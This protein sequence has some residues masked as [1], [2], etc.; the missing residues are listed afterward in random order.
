MNPFSPRWWS[1][2]A[3]V[4]AG[5][6]VTQGAPRTSANYFQ[7][8]ESLNAAGRLQGSANYAAFTS[9]GLPGG[10]QSSASYHAK[11]GPVVPLAGDSPATGPLPVLLGNGHFIISGDTTPAAEDGTDYGRVPVQDDPL[12]HVFTLRNGGTEP[13]TVSDITKSGAGAGEFAVSGVTFPLTLTPGAS[14]EL[15][16]AFDPVLGARR[17]ANLRINFSTAGIAP[18][19]FALQGFGLGLIQVTHLGDSGP[20]SLRDAILAANAQEGDDVIRFAAGVLGTLDLRTALPEVT[21][22]LS[23]EGPGADRLVINRPNQLGLDNIPDFRLFP[24]A[25]GF[26]GRFGLKGVTLR[27]GSDPLAGVVALAAGELVA[28]DCV[29]AGNEATGGTDVTLATGAAVFRVATGAALTAVRCRFEQNRNL[30]LP[31]A[32]LH[33]RVCVVLGDSAGAVELTDCAFRENHT[34]PLA[35]VTL[36]DSPAVLRRCRFEDNYGGNG[37]GLLCLPGANSAASVLVLDGLFL[38]NRS[39]QGGAILSLADGLRVVNSTFTENHSDDFGGAIVLGGSLVGNPA[40]PTTVGF[41]G[42]TAEFVNCT[43][44]GNQGPRT[45]FEPAQGAGGIAIRGLRFGEQIWR[46]HARLR[47]TVVADNDLE[48]IGQPGAPARLDVAWG[49]LLGDLESQGWNFIGA[50]NTNSPAGWI[51]TDRFGIPNNPLTPGLGPLGDYGGPLPTLLPLRFSPLVD[52]ANVAGLNLAADARGLARTLDRPDRPNAAGSDGTDI[53][54]A[55][56]QPPPPGVVPR[57]VL[58]PADVTVDG[59]APADLTA[60]AFGSEPLTFTWRKDGQPVPGGVGPVLHFDRTLPSLAGGYELV[61]A[62]AFGSVTSQVAT[63][64]VRGNFVVNLADHGPGSLR[65]QIIAANANPGPDT[66]RLLVDSPGRILL[67]TP[68]PNIFGELT[69]IGPGPELLALEARG[70]QGLRT[71]SA[72]RLSLMGLAFR[73]FDSGN[74]PVLRIAGSLVVS[75]CVFEANRGAVHGLMDSSGAAEVVLADSRFVDNVAGADLVRILG[76][77]TNR[78]TRCVFERN[79]AGGTTLFLSP[80]EGREAIVDRCLFRDNVGDVG[81]AVLGV[82]GSGQFHTLVVRNSTFAGNRGRFNG[83]AIQN[84]SAYLR[85]EQSTFSGNTAGLHGGAVYAGDNFNLGRARLVNCTLTGNRCGASDGAGN[86]GG[87]YAQ[88]DTGRA[89][90]RNTLVAGNADSGPFLL[91]PDVAGGMTSDGWNLI[92]ITNGSPAFT[93][94]ADLVGSLEAPLE[95]RLSALGDFGGPTPTHLP[96]AGSPAVD[97]GSVVGLSLAADQRGLGRVVDE[98]GYASAEGG[99]GSDIGAVERVTPPDSI[100]IIAAHPADSSVKAGGL[101]TL[102]GGAYGSEPI[103]YQWRK[104][105]APLPGATDWRL[106]LDNL[107]PQDAGN[108][109]LVA[110]N[111]FGSATSHVAVLRVIY[112]RVANGNDAGPGSLRQAVTDANA[113]PGPD[114]IYFLDDALQPISGTAQLETAL[115]LVTGPLNLIGPGADRV[116]V[117]RTGGGT[118]GALRTGA[119]TDLSVSGLTFRNFNSPDGAIYQH[120]GTLTV[121]NCVFDANQSTGNAGVNVWETSRITVTGSTFTGNVA[122]GYG[123]ALRMAGVTTVTVTD[124]RFSNNSTGGNGGALTASAGYYE[125]ST[126]RMERCTFMGNSAQAGGGAA[127]FRGADNGRFHRFT[128]RDC[129]FSGNSAAVLAGAILNGSPYLRLENCTLSGNTAAGHAGAVYCGDNFSGGRVTFVNCT[130][131]GNRC[132]ITDIGADGG[133]VV[134]G[135]GPGRASFR[136]TL[137]AGNLDLGVNHQAPDLRSYGADSLVSEGWN[138]IGITNGVFAPFSHP[139]DLLGSLDAP[140]LALL[141]PLDD[142]GG[143]VPTHLLLRGNPALDAGNVAGLDLLTDARGLPRVVDQP[144]VANAAGG[145]GSDIGAVE[146][147]LFALPIITEQPQ[148]VT[149]TKADVAE[150]VPV[151][152]RVVAV[153]AETFAWFLVR[154]GATN[155]VAGGTAAVLTLPDTRRADEG[156]YFAVVTNG[157]GAVTSEVAVLRLSLPQRIVAP[158][159]PSAGGLRLRFQDAD[160]GAGDPGAFELQATGELRGAATVWEAVPVVFTVVEGAVQC[161]VPIDPTSKHRFY[162]IIAR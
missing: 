52:A 86:G 6:V 144:G 141:S 9:L 66:I 108:Y 106:R 65:E 111:A 128:V 103:T 153:D 152:F 120:Y 14:A 21:E 85:I 28:E 73:G 124:C 130:V 80:Q 140:R 44:V 74:D 27:G 149:V 47:N 110:A 129:T 39:S 12:I 41:S 99:D 88:P 33:G 69:I 151:T 139:A 114:S 5:A 57:L 145:D 121:S 43:I 18:Y 20:R 76:G 89:V 49:F 104:N 30:A 82:Y 132:G 70:F 136:N 13:F 143:P 78:I 54:A 40:A 17:P 95:A 138:L 67:E 22:T 36:R 155:P 4:L 91:A 134:S 94:A 72:E 53:G 147:S 11:G 77:Q 3:A 148:S 133:G 84:H 160:G 125:D 159:F 92:G 51:A 23:I 127:E 135:H 19:E 45:G 161:D 42:G 156:A 126:L 154:N 55:E 60:D 97:R 63:L 37:G 162:R 10:E 158:E 26:A 81:A 25:P 101:V 142:H 109:D 107:Q 46:S 115:P 150:V 75:N 56:S 83:G 58:Q 122:G 79:Q 146:G 116:A 90:L 105:G 48:E 1:L 119:I 34:A 131:T 31:A 7:P 113:E 64:T 2:V 71:T 157:S 112:F 62:N 98:P 100:P 24:L 16:I 117:A 35:P 68:L 59:L 118:F 15:P 61:A 87:I 38:R 137:V 93:H 96:L 123:G 50:V 8:A 32:V 29:F 102:T